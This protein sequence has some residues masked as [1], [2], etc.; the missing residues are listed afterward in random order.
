MKP[1]DVVILLKII[2]LGDQSWYHHTLAES[3]NISQ[4][5]VTQSLN[6]SRFSGL[7]DANRKEVSRLGLLEFLQYGVKYSFPEQP[8]ALVR[9]I[10]TAHS[11]PPLSDEIQSQDPYVWPHAS[12]KV[13]GQSI[14]PLYRSV[15]N[16]VEKDEKLYELLTLVDAI[17]VG[18]VREK[19]LA[20]HHL[21][22][23]FSHG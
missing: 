15:P 18:R 4:S 9:G 12:G 1:Q 19:Q 20:L 17:R 5:E 22:E 8:G 6:R 23:I 7:I 21:N 2:A 13:R 11:A 3:L 16:A 10:P 14:E